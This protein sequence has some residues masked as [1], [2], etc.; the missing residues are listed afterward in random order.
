M[1]TDDVKKDDELKEENEL[2]EEEIMKEKGSFL[3]RK[4]IE[5]SV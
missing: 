3:K 2:S 5:I 1:S 4:N